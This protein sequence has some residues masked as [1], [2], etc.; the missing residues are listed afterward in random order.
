MDRNMD[1]HTPDENQTIEATCGSVRGVLMRI[2]QLRVSVLDVGERDR[3]RDMEHHP[4]ITTTRINKDEMAKEERRDEMR[5]S[6]EAW[7]D[8]PKLWR[9]HL[10]ETRRDNGTGPSH[11]RRRT[12][13]S[14]ATND[15]RIISS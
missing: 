5:M 6:T 4:T 14:K 15:I 7:V 9:V 13:G 11:C 3:V 2:M 10:R 1:M 12:L 8:T